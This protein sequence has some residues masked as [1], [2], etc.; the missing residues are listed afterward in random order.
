M[1][2]PSPATTSIEPRTIAPELILGTGLG[3]IRPERL[4]ARQGRSVPAPG[5][6][7][8]IGRVVFEGCSASWQ[9]VFSATITVMSAS[10]SR[11]VSAKHPPIPLRQPENP[12]FDDQSLVFAKKQLQR[13][14]RPSTFGTRNEPVSLSP[15]R[16]TF[17]RDFGLSRSRT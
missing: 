12:V 17:R 1:P 10:I 8:M 3:R 6:G 11:P 15:S 13:S 16:M 7:G 4:F 14:R 5:P 2:D 9:I